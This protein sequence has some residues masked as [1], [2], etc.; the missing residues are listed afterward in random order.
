MDDGS[1]AGHDSSLARVRLANSVAPRSTT[2]V[3]YKSALLEHIARER[4][5]WEHAGPGWER[6]YVGY[7]RDRRL[8]IQRC[9]RSPERLAQHYIFMSGDISAV[10]EIG[11]EVPSL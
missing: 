10:I 8:D 7:R 4:A 2:S 5:F 9:G 6:A 3:P 11:F 1:Y